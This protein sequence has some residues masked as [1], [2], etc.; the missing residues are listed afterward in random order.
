[1]SRNHASL[2]NG[3][4]REGGDSQN[5][6]AVWRGTGHEGRAET[7]LAIY[8]SNSH[9]M[10]SSSTPEQLIVPRINVNNLRRQNRRRE[11]SL[12]GTLFF[13]LSL[14]YLFRP[15]HYIPVTDYV[16]RTE[17]IMKTTPL[18]DGHND[19]PALIRVELK[20]HIYDR[21]FTFRDGLLS[22]TDLV[23]LRSGRVGGQFW[24]A[25]V[26]CVDGMADDFNVPTASDHYGT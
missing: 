4:R 13:V 25:F 17:R 3:A 26:P 20:N 12:L 6:R 22:T 7:R 23:K 18:I 9:N 8:D 21:R 16:A 1:M 24:S 14:G 10:L 15:D 5:P 2:A 11:Y 19:M